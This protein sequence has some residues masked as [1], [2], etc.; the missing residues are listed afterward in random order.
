MPLKNLFDHLFRNHR[1]ELVHFA[2]QRAVEMAEDVVQESFLRLMQHPDPQ[3]I[4]NHRAY[5]Y[6]LTGNTLIDYQRKLAV[7]QRYHS[8][9]P[10][11][12]SLPAET[13][14]LDV[15]LHHQQVLRGVLQAL[16]GLPPMQRSIFLLHRFDGLTYQQI[17]K[18]LKM[19]RSS[20][21]RQF[22]AAL[23]HCFAASLSG[24]P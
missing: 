13:P 7:R 21:E 22:Y 6:K 14:G 1:N 4:E 19:S 5:L 12:D 18:L 11:L 10:D 16:D 20:V 3:T 8:E 24:K 23:E 17:G 9:T 2:G 15:A